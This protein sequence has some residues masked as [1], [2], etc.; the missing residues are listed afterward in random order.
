[1]YIS[2]YKTSDNIINREL[3]S[4][5]ANPQEYEE[6]LRFFET[7]K[8]I[9]KPGNI[10]LAPPKV[11]H[12]G[13]LTNL[14]LQM[15][16]AS[17]FSPMQ[18][19]LGHVKAAGN[20]PLQR[21]AG[22]LSG[23]SFLGMP[24]ASADNNVDTTLFPD[25]ILV[26]IDS[27]DS[28][29]PRHHLRRSVGNN[30]ES[31]FL[32]LPSGSLATEN[33]KS[34]LINKNLMNGKQ[35]W[36][37]A[38]LINAVV[39]YINTNSNGM[40]KVARRMLRHSGLMGA[41]KN[42]EM[43]EFNQ[44]KTVTAWMHSLLFEKGI[45]AFIVNE[46]IKVY[47]N[48]S[49]GN[50][51]SPQNFAI[52]LLQKVRQGFTNDTGMSGSDGLQRGAL[53]FIA[54]NIF[55]PIMPTFFF[56]AILDPSVHYSIGSVEWGYLHAG[57]CFA[58]GAEINLQSISASEL[59][60]LGIVLDSM[61]KEG[62]SDPSLF[63]LF[64]LPAML[65]HVKHSIDTDDVIDINNIIEPSGIKKAILEEYLLA[66]DKFN[67]AN[68]PVTYFSEAL[69]S[70]QT[71][72]QL[73]E[74]VID[75]YCNV[76]NK[77]EMPYVSYYKYYNSGLTC[78]DVV[79]GAINADRQLPSLDSIY[80][81][82]NA[83]IADAFANVD[84]RIIY[85]VISAIDVG[86]LE[87]LAFSEI[88]KTRVSFAHRI[89][90]KTALGYL[91]FSQY[92][93]LAIRQDVDIFAASK[94]N[95]ERVYALIKEKD[96]YRIKRTDDDL[97]AYFELLKNFSPE[98][99]FDK[100]VRL[101]L[102]KEDRA[103][104]QS[105]DQSLKVLAAQLSQLHRDI[106]YVGLNNEGYEKTAAEKTRNF[107]LS[108]IPFHDC[109]MHLLAAEEK[110]AAVACSAD[111]VMVGPFA[112]KG[113]MMSTQ[114]AKTFGYGARIALG[115]AVSGFAARQSLRMAMK[116]AMPALSRFAILPAS[117]ELN[118]LALTDLGIEFL[119]LFDPGLE[120]AGRL[121]GAIVTQV[122]KGVGIASRSA[123]ALKKLFA[124]LQRKKIGQSITSPAKLYDTAR[125]SASGLQ[126]P[127]VKLQKKTPGGQEIYV[128]VNPVNN[129]IFG[130]KYTLSADKTLV[131]IPLD[132]AKRLDNLRIQGLGGHGAKIRGRQWM[133]E[134]R[135]PSEHVHESLREVI[136]SPASGH[137]NR[138]PMHH[139]PQGGAA[140]SV[141]RSW[142]AAYRAEKNL[143]KQFYIK[144]FG[145]GDSESV[146][147]P[148]I[149]ISLHQNSLDATEY[150]RAF[151][152]LLED[153]KTAVRSWSLVE[154]DVRSYSDGS[155]NLTRLNKR[156]INVE[157]NQK[158]RDGLP[159]AADEKEVYDGLMAFLRADIP[160]QRGS[161]LR[162]A[163]Y[164][165]GH[166]IPWLHDI[167]VGDIVTNYPQLMSVSGDD[168]FARLFAEQAAED[169]PEIEKGL[170]A[171]VIYR[172]D[173]GEKCTPLIPLAASTVLD[174]VEYLYSP[175]TYFRVK[176]IS[177]ANGISQYIFP[178]KRIG[179]I[180]EEI[181]EVPFSAKN[182]FSGNTYSYEPL[183]PARH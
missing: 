3:L 142:R 177:I 86:E 64:M 161:Y 33:I 143:P 119:R 155:P 61:L 8:S 24:V 151:A 9:R 108:L 4:N 44:Q 152:R 150:E 38:D 95:E 50:V 82:Q 71:R 13:K 45:E 72:S 41:K 105:P 183:P 139:Y 48:E 78:A 147:F 21:G 92:V 97:K 39:K 116:K 67:A 118:R 57:L 6:T 76:G 138:P 70:Y 134:Q 110:E 74:K 32:Y 27:H 88:K 112:V 26:K 37:N 182:L 51:T 121:S 131:P 148:E 149:G 141:E 122:T 81:R 60:S 63:K 7:L 49:L 12:K 103:L 80:E 167:I 181:S 159:F 29:F 36:G 31:A 168:A 179:V 22:P 114:A 170:E 128:R 93:N 99:E 94:N 136:L 154:D 46:F 162:I 180:L 165:Q 157:I 84:K 58:M 14:A 127:V 79:S 146:L 130:R 107:F 96:G 124:A 15:L 160:R 176:G 144:T 5:E 158:L 17:A 83:D 69:A 73:A 23:Q 175:K 111:I 34:F 20:N 100:N 135:H 25:A 62:L 91:A 109:L 10:A 98:L 54:D 104:L 129:D 166:H 11:R 2:D 173:N 90:P 126:V 115:E 47:R 113:L 132:L 19:I 52:H 68:D 137:G 28:I 117:R 140:G 172:I 102:H 101:V 163:E 77:D 89:K 174:E 40:E 75:T 156:P 30:D 120:M 169:G 66:C 35:S 178:R 42:E 145:D 125:L 56:D 16:Y 1:M 133:N 153:E 85:K 55:L 65:Y 87:F 43:S 18:P 53:E 164:R 106:L 171:L 123:P 59:L